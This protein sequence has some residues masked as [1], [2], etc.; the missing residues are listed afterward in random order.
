MEAL[1]DW[2]KKKT[3]A[4]DALKKRIKENDLSGVYLFWGEEEYTKDFYAAKLR[5]LAT[6]APVP[7]F[8]Y[9]LFD[10][11]THTPGDFEEATFVLPYL[12]EHR[13]IEIRNLSLSALS[14]EDGEAYARIFASVPDY[15]T[16]LILLRSA[17]YTGGKG[18]KAE[19]KSGSGAFLRAVEENGLSVEF[20]PEKG[21]KLCTWV[22]KHF[23]ARHVS[24]SPG[25]PSALIAY[26]GTDMYTLQGEIGKLCDA[27]EGTPLT[28]QDVRTYCCQNESYVF[29]DIASCMNRN[30]LSGA[31]RI[32]SGLR[33]TPD[34]VMMAVGYL[35][36]HYQLL[37]LVKAGL[38]SGMSVSRIAAEQKQPAW[39]V[40]KAAS[41]V[42]NTD[43]SRLR[44]AVREIAAADTRIKGTRADPKAVLELLLYR[45]CSY[46]K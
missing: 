34:A 35:A 21:E 19:K 40:Q 8:N 25:L 27:Y 29:F 31:R 10:A 4:L 37:S 36:S 1:A 22:A 17:A 39:K 12:W 7:E 45:I 9:L 41:A 30:D 14:V 16:V 32:L 23:A 6:D 5:K 38:D 44:Y 46:G 2:G 11:E 3:S 43:A 20:E 18:E 24:V 28:E 15:L 26:C 13:V 42:A 33:M